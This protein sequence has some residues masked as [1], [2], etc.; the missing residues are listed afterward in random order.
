MKPNNYQLYLFVFHFFFSTSF[1]F[2]K[3]RYFIT[4]HLTYEPI[5]GLDVFNFAFSHLFFLYST[6][7]EKKCHYDGDGESCDSFN[8][9]EFIRNMDKLS[10]M[11]YDLP[12]SHMHRFTHFVCLRY[13][14]VDVEFIQN[15]Y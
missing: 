5:N 6:R 1:L 10:E 15:V 2:L 3:H 7:E 9:I 11:L 4:T 12:L 13:V 8:G 14:A